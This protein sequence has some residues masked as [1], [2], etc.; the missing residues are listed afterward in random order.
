MIKIL[1]SGHSVPARTWDSRAH[2]DHKICSSNYFVDFSI[3]LVQDSAIIALFIVFVFGSHMNRHV[4]VTSRWLAPSMLLLLQYK[5][6]WL[7]MIQN[8]AN[9]NFLCLFMIHLG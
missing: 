4:H 6:V 3:I 2:A 1:K 9:T 8:T 5:I 7:K